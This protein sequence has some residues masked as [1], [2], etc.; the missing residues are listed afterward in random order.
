[1]TR[2]YFIH[3]T[4]CGA[5]EEQRPIVDAFCA[6]HPELKRVDVDLAIEE[7]KARAWIPKVTPTHVLLRNG[8]KPIIYEGEATLEELEEWLEA[9]R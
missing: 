4:G 1:M 9:T 7:W 2:Y 5:C 8:R 6:K 3:Q